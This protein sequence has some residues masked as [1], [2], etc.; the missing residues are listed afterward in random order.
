MFPIERILKIQL[1]LIFC[2]TIPNAVM[3]EF[4]PALHLVSTAGLYITF[5]LSWLY[6]L[7]HPKVLKYKN[8][9]LWFLVYFII[10]SA[11]IYVDIAIEPEYPLA[12]MLG[13]PKSVIEFFRNSM[14]LFMYMLLV[15]LYSK[16]HDYSFLVKSYI[17]LNLP[18]TIWFVMHYGNLYSSDASIDDMTLSSLVLASSASNAM[19]FSVLFR[20]KWSN[21]N[22][23]NKF[24]FIL[25]LLGGLYVWGVLAKRGA[26]LWFFVTLMSYK[27]IISKKPSKTIIVLL[28][29]LFIVYLCMP[30]IIQLV[31]NFSPFLA[32][33]MAATFIEGD[34]SGR[35][36]EGGG[37]FYGIRQ[38]LDSPWYGSYFRLITGDRM[39]QGMYPHNL[40]I[41]LLITMGILG[42][43]PLIL[44][45]LYIVRYIRKEFLNFI[46]RNQTAMELV[47]FVMLINTILLM[48]SSGTP[49]LNMNYWLIFAI[50][51]NINPKKK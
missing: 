7:C 25:I 11:F 48:M 22:S 31:S 9:F 44:F 39:W 38:F 41:E 30:L 17:L 26:I 28:I 35:M 51:L 1:I 33:R 19:L 13:C 23:F 34:T 20:P 15:P 50:L 49:L 36:N 46:D 32:E 40:I 4:I 3:D 27:L 43:I 29:L 5:F 42:I 18:L 45:I 21:K 16:I 2:F 47:F 8:S 12:E 6:V 10:Y 37:Y 24:C 14:I